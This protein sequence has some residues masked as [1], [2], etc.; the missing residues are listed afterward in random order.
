MYSETLAL[1]YAALLHQM[2]GDITGVLRS[3][4]AVVTL[5][6]RYGFAYYGDWAQVLIGWARGQE[7]PAEGVVTI[8]SALKRLD[9]KRAQARRPYYLSL[10]A[11]TYRRAGNRDRA[12]A[13]LDAAIT[14]AIDRADTSWLPAL[15][16]QK[17]EFE[18]PFERDAMLRRALELARAQHSRALEARILA[19]VT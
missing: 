13:T 16:F 17:S 6:E 14:L 7:R 10:L 4:E 15:Y 19:A 3:A 12:A 9:A 8:E 5:C 11:D 18:A 2:R 1:A